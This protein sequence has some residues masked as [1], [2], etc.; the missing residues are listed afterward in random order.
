MAL[1][2]WLRGVSGAHH[3][4]ASPNHGTSSLPV[5]VFSNTIPSCIELCVLAATGSPL[6]ASPVPDASLQLVAEGASICMLFKP[7]VSKVCLRVN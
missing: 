5:V 3:L 6:L 7:T 1:R 2:A 4:G